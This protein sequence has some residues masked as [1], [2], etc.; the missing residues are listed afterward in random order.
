VRQ[1]RVISGA[2][3]LAGGKRPQAAS[4]SERRHAGRGVAIGPAGG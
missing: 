2:S 3:G 1:H 4:V